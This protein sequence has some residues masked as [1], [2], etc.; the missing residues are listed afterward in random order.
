MKGQAM[1][2]RNHSMIYY[3]IKRHPSAKVWDEV[4]FPRD[5]AESAQ[6]FWVNALFRG[7][8]VERVG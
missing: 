5:K 8:L 7:Y 3:Y 2:E 4:V 6:R 1:T